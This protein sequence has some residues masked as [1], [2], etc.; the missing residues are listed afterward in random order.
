MTQ[1]GYSL[2]QAAKLAGVPKSTFHNWAKENLIAPDVADDKGN[3]TLY[4]QEQVDR[5]KELDDKRKAKKAGIDDQSFSLFEGADDNLR[6]DDDSCAAVAVPE[7]SAI[8]PVKKE[9]FSDL[10]PTA[11]NQTCAAET[12]AVP[13]QIVTLAQRADRIRRLQADVQRGIINIGLELIAAKEQCGHGNWAAWIEA[14][15]AWTQRTAN[16][17]MRVAERFGKLENVF[18]FQPSTLQAM[19]KLPAGAEQEFIDAQAAVGKPL[20]KLSARQVQE[21][22]REFNQRRDDLSDVGETFSFFKGKAEKTQ[23]VDHEAHKQSAPVDS[24]MHEAA[25]A[26]CGNDQTQTAAQVESVPADDAPNDAELAA[27]NFIESCS[28]E[29]LRRIQAAIERRF[30]AED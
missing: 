25:V 27:L 10:T 17:F 11:N 6:G 9:M 14:E 1:Q 12:V 22:V 19:L 13:A 24:D 8:L 2:R 20:E 18:Q 26:D 3:V 29:S 28:V 5:A 23:S 4:S 30:A 21:A 16:N 15:F 7:S